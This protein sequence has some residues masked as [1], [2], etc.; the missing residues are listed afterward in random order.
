[1]SQSDWEYISDHL[2]ALGKIWRKKKISNFLKQFLFHFNLKVKQKWTWN[3]RKSDFFRNEALHQ[4]SG[5]VELLSYVLTVFH[6]RGDLADLKLAMPP[7][8]NWA[9]EKHCF[10]KFL[11][12]ASNWRIVEIS[13][14]LAEKHV[15]TQNNAQNWIFSV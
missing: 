3:N 11:R 4:K 6:D 5:T 15:N 12:A 7:D 13:K 2:Q 14:I 10:Q 1:M 8:S 9:H